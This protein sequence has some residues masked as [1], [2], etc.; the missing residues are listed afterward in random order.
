MVTIRQLR[1]T[2]DRFSLS[3]RGFVQDEL[4]CGCPEQVFEQIRILKGDATPDQTDMSLVIGERLLVSFARIEEIR[5]VEEKVP[6]LIQ[7]GV[8]YRDAVKL[9]RLRLV[10]QGTAT[11]TE[12]RLLESE[13]TKYEKVNVHF[14]EE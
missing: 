5:P 9:N 14:F 6:G 2:I 13:S 11:E 10:I 1:D 8:I 3:I 7:S 12:K 4:G